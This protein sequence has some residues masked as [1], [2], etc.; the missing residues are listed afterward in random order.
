MTIDTITDGLNELFKN[1][2]VDITDKILEYL[3]QY[4]TYLVKVTVDGEPENSSIGY[5]VVFSYEGLRHHYANRIHTSSDFRVSV[6]KVTASNGITWV[7]NIDH[8]N[9]PLNADPWDKGRICV[10][11]T[12]YEEHA[13]ITKDEWEKF[14]NYEDI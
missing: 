14:L 2:F 8:P 13:T 10:F 4:D 7:V 6:G 9:R 5:M 12:V 3:N 1:N 11:E